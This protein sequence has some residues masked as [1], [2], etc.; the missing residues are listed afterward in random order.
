[1]FPEMQEICELTGFNNFDIASYNDIP[2]YQARKVSYTLRKGGLI[3]T[4]RRE[5]RGLVFE[6]V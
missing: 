1:M 6:L 2:V 4:V 3:K 5:R